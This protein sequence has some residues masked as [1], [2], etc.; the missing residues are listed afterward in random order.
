MSNKKARKNVS[1]GFIGF[2]FGLTA[3]ILLIGVMG[4]SLREIEEDH[5]D[6]VVSSSGIIF[7]IVLPICLVAGLV[8]CNIGLYQYLQKKNRYTKHMFTIIGGALIL[9]TFYYTYFIYLEPGEEPDRMC[10]FSESELKCMDWEMQTNDKSISDG[11]EYDMI[12]LVFSHDTKL[13]SEKIVLSIAECEPPTGTAIKFDFYNQ[14]YRAVVPCR[15]LVVNKSFKSEFKLTYFYWSDK[16][17]DLL[18]D[19]S[20]GVIKAT[21]TKTD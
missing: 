2:V 3:V 16:K 12:T 20:E 21:V 15:G 9:I 1:A 17:M 6:S 5:Y 13:L 4:F 14:N 11:D 19:V 10:E 7:T 18:S 8:L